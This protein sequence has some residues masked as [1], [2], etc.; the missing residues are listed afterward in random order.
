VGD[1]SLAMIAAG[2]E[3]NVLALN[4]LDMYGCQVSDRG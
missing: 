3:S 4:S 1:R 2:L